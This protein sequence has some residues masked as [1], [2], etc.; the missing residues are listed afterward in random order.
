MLWIDTDA[1]IDD[2]ISLLILVSKRDVHSII[3]ISLVDGNITIE[4][5]VD[6]MAFLNDL[7]VSGDIKSLNRDRIPYYVGSHGPIIKDVHVK[8]RWPGHAED[9]L[10]GL[11]QLD[12]YNDRYTSSCQK[13]KPESKHAV[14][15]LLEAVDKY[16][17]Q[18]TI[19]ALGPLTN[20][21]LATSIDCNFL[22]K[23]KRI[24][25]MGGSLT[26]QGN[27]NRA[28]EFNFHYDPEAAHILFQGVSE[29][30]KVILDVVPWE[31]CI[32]LSLDWEF[33]DG[34]SSD[35]HLSKILI[36]VTKLAKT[37]RTPKS[38]GMNPID[39][40]FM[41]F[42]GFFLPDVCATLVLI[43]PKS[44]IHSKNLELAVELNGTHSRGGL[45]A[46]WIDQNKISNC[47]VILKISIDSLK[48]MMRDIFF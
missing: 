19:L 17:G 14:N 47:N 48:Q 30:P 20:I 2:F 37:M 16:P 40:Y 24:I 11:S 42:N 13:F 4:K 46:D 33:L 35:N 6:A 5:A 25:V 18:I 7:I 21:A 12:E 44:I 38:I 26:A 10:G 23:V 27:T 43:D 39:E 15:A 36:Q 41:K 34:I 3:G 8:F 28:A 1:G 45:Y 31:A 29:L 32:D 22:S 9:G